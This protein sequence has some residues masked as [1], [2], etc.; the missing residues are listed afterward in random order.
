MEDATSD[1]YRANPEFS[2]EHMHDLKNRLTV[3]KGVAQML[4]RQVRQDDWQRDKIIARVDRLQDEIALLEQLVH[5]FKS[6]G[7]AV[8]PDRRHDVLH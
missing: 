6:D 7:N 1:A 2:A 5:D 4:D 8:D 3:V